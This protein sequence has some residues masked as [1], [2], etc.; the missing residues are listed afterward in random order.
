MGAMMEW[1][2]AANGAIRGAF[3]VPDHHWGMS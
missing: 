1:L 2:P 3:T